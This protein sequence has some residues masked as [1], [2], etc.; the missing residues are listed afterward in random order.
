TDTVGDMLYGWRLTC[1]ATI[2]APGERVKR[3]PAAPSF[4]RQRFR[5]VAQQQ[6]IQGR[7]QLSRAR[8][9]PYVHNTRYA[10]AIGIVV[11]RR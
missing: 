8:R 10:V 6:Q 11:S 5:V 4:L 2:T 9:A 1:G 7:R 3:A